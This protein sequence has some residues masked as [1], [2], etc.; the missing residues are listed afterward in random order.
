MFGPSPRMG[1]VDAARSSYDLM[2]YYYGRNDYL[3]EEINRMTII[4]D[5]AFWVDII[6]KITPVDRLTIR[7]SYIQFDQAYAAFVANGM[8]YTNVFENDIYT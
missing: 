2:E 1:S 3:A 6:S 4:L 8:S 7:R 5:E